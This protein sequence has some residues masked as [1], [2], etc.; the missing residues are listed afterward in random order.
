MKVLR[1]SEN[2][3]KIDIYN[4]TEG[5]TEKLLEAIDADLKIGAWILGED[6]DQKGNVRE[7]LVIKEAGED[8][9]IY[10]TISETF[11]TKFKKALDY[12]GEIN[13]IRVT[14][15]TSKNGREFISMKLIA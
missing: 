10:G 12:V 4:M 6:E 9:L 15:G 2:L 3:T 5:D 13:V 11:I 1:T 7:V 8:G 14:G